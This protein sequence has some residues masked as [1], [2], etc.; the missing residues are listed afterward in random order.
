M[1]EELLRRS[2]PDG[3][4]AAVGS[5]EFARSVL[6]NG[7]RV[8]TERIPYVR[9]V[10]LG[11]WF[12]AGSRCETP[13]ENG[14]SHFIEHMMFKGT[15]SRSARAIAEIF[16]AVG[17]Q[18][19]AFT[20]RENTAYYARVLDRHFAL[21]VDV[22]GDMLLHSLFQ[23]E[24]I[25]KEKGVIQEEIRMYE[26]TPDELVHDL[27]AEGIIGQ[28]PLGQPV[29]GK[30][31][32]VSAFSRQDVLAY[33][34]KWYVPANLVV[35][36][37]GNITHRQVVD[38]VSAQLGQIPARPVPALLLWEPR[39]ARNILRD[40]DTEQVH[41][42]LGGPGLPRNDPRR[43]AMMIMD[44][45]LGGGMSSRLFQELREERALVYSTY[46][47][48]TGFQEAGMFGVYAGT[49]PENLL[50]VLDVVRT[51]LRRLQ[52][53]GITQV[54]LERAKEQVKG[55]FMLSLESTSSRMTRIAKMEMYEE[56]IKS[57]DAVMAEIDAVQRSDVQDL[58]AQLA[59]P[60]KMTL[61]A[62]GPGVRKK[63]A[64]QYPA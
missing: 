43:Y 4:P 11:F 52:Q 50:Q 45:V 35:A 6:P 15:A 23:P 44:T 57:P 40:K 63:L 34:E 24:D 61:A 36:A 22:V 16:D 38:A 30:A 13:K 20:A 31:E 33:L 37:A 47:F 7:L 53:E 42:C 54:E 26:D 59:D 62:I 1:P 3:D 41:L 2:Q 46:S 39:P 10:S 25:E 9:S 21:A 32:N 28:H 14:I 18:L 19:N 29:L 5:F 56:R 51:E 27:F 48:H 49:S 8:V 55:G 64:D 58:A 17:G 60:D 12:G